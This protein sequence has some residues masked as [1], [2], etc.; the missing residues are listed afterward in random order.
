MCGGDAEAA[1]EA[2]AEGVEA[3]LG[4]ILLL[5]SSCRTVEIN[6]LARLERRDTASAND[7]TGVYAAARTRSTV[8]TFIVDESA[9]VK[10]VDQIVFSENEY[11]RTT[12]I[13]RYETTLNDITSVPFSVL[14]R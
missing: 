10:V 13:H 8:G 5:L 3:I 14:F 7:L 1:P 9:S 4:P 6:R 2:G 11:P 12:W